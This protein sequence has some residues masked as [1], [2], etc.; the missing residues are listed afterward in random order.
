VSDALNLR[1]HDPEV[2]AQDIR[3]VLA[4]PVLSSALDR[5]EQALVDEI[6]LGKFDGTPEFEAI[7][8]ELCRTLRTVRSFRY[9]LNKIPQLDELRAAGFKPQKAEAEESD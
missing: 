9:G 1:R 3:R 7:E 6:A 2:V 4:D 8:R 5:Y